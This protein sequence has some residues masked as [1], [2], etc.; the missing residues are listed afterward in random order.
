MHF[1]LFC[2]SH[3]LWMCIKQKAFQ[4]D[5]EIHSF[6]V[7]TTYLKKALAGGGSA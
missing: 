7:D 1:V 5:V 4:F 3:T 2:Q 6:Q